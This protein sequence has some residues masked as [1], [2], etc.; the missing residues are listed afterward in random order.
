MGCDASGNGNISRS[1]GMTTGAGVIFYLEK[2]SL[3]SAS[4]SHTFFSASIRLS[5]LRNP[6]IKGL[7]LSATVGA[8]AII[9]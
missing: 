5:S 3:E 1:L 6:T 8:V 9:R 2:L 4:S 7:I